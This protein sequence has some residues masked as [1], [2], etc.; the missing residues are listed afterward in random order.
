MCS[1]SAPTWPET[2]LWRCHLLWKIFTTCG[3]GSTLDLAP[4]FNLLSF[5]FLFVFFSNEGDPR[6]LPP[7]NTN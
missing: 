2:R 7:P 1:W 4:S 3:K 6:F 5:P